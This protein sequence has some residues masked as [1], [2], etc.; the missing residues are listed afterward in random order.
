MTVNVPRSMSLAAWCLTAM[1]LAVPSLSQAEEAEVGLQ[2]PPGFE[3][4]RYA[5]DELAHDIFAMTIDSLGRVVVSGPGYVKI[6]IDSDGDGKADQA[7]KFADGPQTGSQGL[8]FVGRDLLCTGDDGLIRYRDQNRDDRADG[9]PD[10]FLKIPT[11]GEH[12]SHAVRRGPDGWWYIILGN[13]SE[14]GPGYATLKTSPIKEPH[15]GVVLR[16]APD[17]SGGEIVVDGIRN[18]YDFDFNALGELFV[19]DSDGE[20]DISLPWYAPSKLFHAVPGSNL[21]WVTDSWKMPDYMID[22]PPVVCSTGRSSP[23]GIVCYRH[24]QFPSKYRGGMFLLDWTFGKVWYSPVHRQGATFGGHPEEFV[25]A[26]GQFGFAPTDAE[27]GPDGSLYLCVGGRGTHGTVYKVRYVGTPEQPAT[28]VRSL[29]LPDTTTA[30]QKLNY[31]LAI[32][33]PGSSWSRARWVPVATALGAQPFLN[34]AMAEERPVAERL[35]AIE[36]V[37]ELFAGLPAS[38]VEI[39]ATAKPAEVR[40]HACWSIAVRP[41][42]ALESK[43]ISTYLNDIDPLV[44]RR[45]VEAIGRHPKLSQSQAIGLTRVMDDESREV[46]MAAV[47]LAPELSAELLKEVADLCRKRSW[48]AAL[49]M[50]LGYTWRQQL[51]NFSVQTYGL[52]VGQRALDAKIAPSLKLEAVRLLQTAL[53]DLGSMESLPPVF[54]G[55]V[56]SLELQPFER[57]L[58]QVRVAAAKLFPTGDEQMDLELSR[59]LA[60]LAPSNPE[61]LEKFLARITPESHPTSDLHY[62]IAAARIAVPRGNAQQQKIAQAL[63]DLD[64][65]FAARQL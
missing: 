11:G 57:E 24:T 22:S 13:A 44:R 17:L 6:L 36:I 53:G 47:R 52:E 23:T 25:V 16:L 50:T 61:V 51:Q 37:T 7:K 58:D 48:R 46:R 2:V 64:R 1:L 10:T 33:Q 21:G 63:V 34:A 35:R 14:V 49:T 39:L 30:E 41:D 4:T 32:P 60:M 38:A 40:S 31:C 62:L 27:V 3:A 55:Y 42:E 28:P 29:D 20:R 54:D 9:P 43:Q 8:Y 45:A 12:N 5:T 59:L 26:Q 65:K 56:G 19:F 15:A 18:A